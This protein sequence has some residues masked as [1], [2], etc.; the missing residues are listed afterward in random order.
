MSSIVDA[1]DPPRSFEQVEADDRRRLVIDHTPRSILAFGL[2][3]SLVAVA[4]WYSRPT[5][6][7]A[8]ILVGSVYVLILAT[9]AALIQMRPH[10]AVASAVLT[11]SALCAAMLGYSPMVQGSGELCVLAVNVLL[12]GFAVAFPIGVRNQ[13]LVSIVPLA[14]YPIILELGTRTAYP[15][16]YSGTAL[17]S[18][19]CVLGLGART[20]DRYR[21]QIL[22]DGFRQAALAAENSRLNE[23]ARAAD[24]AKSD[25]MS[26]LSHELRGPVGNILGFSEILL[27]DKLNDVGEQQEIV[28]S[29]RDQSQRVHELID[30]MLQIDRSNF[31]RIPLQL[32]EF[33]VSELLDRVRS[34]LP[35]HWARHNVQISWQA[36][37]RGERMRS[38]R[39]KLE[40]I[41]R[42]LV[43]NAVKHTRE[44][45]VSVTAS[46]D[47]A[48]P[49]VHF[50][51]TDSGEGM[52]EESV[53]HIF[54]R[55]FQAKTAGAGFGLGL[56]IVKHFA[57]ALGGQVRAESAPGLGARFEVIVPLRSAE[58]DARFSATAPPPA[59]KISAVQS[60]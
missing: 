31:V 51:V 28:Q 9:H 38:D 25:L 48:G 18:F 26:M 43:H 27:D 49:L 32:E 24:R 13:L 40:A 45:S 33:D 11:V 19:L 30:A 59:R 42:N 60:N 1:I 10:L 29:I 55:Y 36:P 54:E 52:S 21:R 3:V 7:D 14:G 2:L 44:G 41:L 50:T 5:H 53:A 47:P 23:E 17:L 8:L 39:I 6:R 34:E 22:L 37:L 35:A 58:Q 12:G 15:V 56:F 20:L 4:E 16:W 57:D 46:I